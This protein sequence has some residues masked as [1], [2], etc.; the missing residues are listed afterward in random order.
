M[1]ELFEKVHPD[2]PGEK[3]GVGLGARTDGELSRASRG[4][5]GTL[6]PMA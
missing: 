5:A 4:A 1:E 6:R 3:A 2:K